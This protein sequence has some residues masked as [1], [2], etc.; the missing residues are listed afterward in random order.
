M[1]WNFKIVHCDWC[2]IKL[3][4]VVNLSESDV[5]SI[6]TNKVNNC[7]KKFGKWLKSSR[8]LKMISL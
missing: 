4:L 8:V 2:N 3:V 6:I 7:E 5:T 1:C